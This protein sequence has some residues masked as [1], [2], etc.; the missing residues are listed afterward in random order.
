M[1]KSRYPPVIFPSRYSIITFSENM[2]SKLSILYFPK[3]DVI[4]ILLEL[5]SL[6]S[7]VTFLRNIIFVCKK[8]NRTN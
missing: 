3:F 1:E 7:A 5:L 8:R 6:I 4:V 2:V